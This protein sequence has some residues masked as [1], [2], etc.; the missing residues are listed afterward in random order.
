MKSALAAALLLGVSVI[1]SAFAASDDSV[2]VAK[3]GYLFAG[4]KYSTVNGKKAHKYIKSVVLS[5]G[6]ADTTHAYSVNTIDLFGLPIRSD[7]FGDI[8]INSAAGSLTATTDQVCR[9]ELVAAD[10]AA[11]TRGSRVPF[12]SGSDL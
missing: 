6:T 3:Q 2:P 1:G 9:F 10:C 4:G 7:S 8:L 5:G 11:A 12:G